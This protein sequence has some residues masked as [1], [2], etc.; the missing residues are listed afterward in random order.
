M[1]ALISPNELLYQGWRVA[2]VEP[3]GQTFPVGEPLF[4]TTCTDDIIADKYWYDPISKSFQVITKYTSN[5]TP[6]ENQPSTTGSQN[7]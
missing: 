6:G 4:W 1:Q 5:L 3:D 7:L 2:Q